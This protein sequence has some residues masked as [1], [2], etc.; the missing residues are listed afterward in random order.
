MILYLSNA[1]N[2]CVSHFNGNIRPNLTIRELCNFNGH[3]KWP[4]S[5]EILRPKDIISNIFIYNLWRS[6]VYVWWK[7][8][9][10]MFAPISGE[11]ISKQC[12]GFYLINAF[13]FSAAYIQAHFTYE[14]VSMVLRPHIQF[15]YTWNTLSK[16]SMD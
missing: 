6:R 16:G 2:G 13:F 8:S 14:L 10:T 11:G 9:P 12:F 1:L 5:N 15:N 7:C 3:T 4:L